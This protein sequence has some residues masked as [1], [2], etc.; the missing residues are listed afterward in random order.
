MTPFRLSDIE[1]PL[2]GIAAWSGTGKTTLLEALLPALRVRGLD[3]AVIKHAHH[4]FDVDIPGKDSHRLRQA[5]AAPML[6]A[7]GRR[8]ALMMETP[9]QEEPCLPT[10]LNQVLTLS[11]DLVLIEGFKQWP[12]PK[13]ELYRD[14]VGKS[15]RAFEDPWVRAVATT[16]EVTLPPD[17]E[18]LDLDNHGALLDWLMAW[19]L[20]WQAMAKG[21]RHE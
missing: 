8:F 15:L 19:P 16:D 1:T 5:G 18:R 7:S 11:P 21:P 3:V 4:D 13:L 6:V 14:A 12:I 10:L 2:L 17:V 20:R 9:G